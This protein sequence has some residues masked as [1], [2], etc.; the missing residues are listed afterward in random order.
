[1]LRSLYRQLPLGDALRSRISEVIP[2]RYRRRPQ[3]RRHGSISELYFWRKDRDIETVAPVQ[4]FYSFIFPEL[5]TKTDAH[6]WIYDAVGQEI[7]R[8]VFALPHCGLHELKLAAMVPKTV[9]HGTFMW[10]V[11]MPDS[12]ANLPEVQ[13]NLMYFTDRGYVFYL[14]SERQPCF[15]HG[16]DRYAVFQ[17]Q[18][19][20]AHDLF[21]DGAW[22]TYS[23][24][25]EFPLRRDMQD[26]VEVILLNR[27]R[28][29][30]ELSVSLHRGGGQLVSEAKVLVEPRGV[31][32]VCLGGPVLDRLDDA[33][34]YF[35]VDGMPTQWGRPAIMRHFSCGAISTMHC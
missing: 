4:N 29:T 8:D 21:Y 19:Q 1:M 10:H 6:I 28:A 15:V 17:G 14:K 31:G 2:L 32:L 26:E 18:E 16:V 24:R 33:D 3:F 11:R 34:G 25:A 35:Q 7:A 20:V 23:W 30:R 9:M 27:S 22:G 5:D 13:D 12:V